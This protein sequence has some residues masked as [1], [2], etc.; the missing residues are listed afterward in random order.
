MQVAPGNLD[1][2]KFLKG[3]KPSPAFTPQVTEGV[4]DEYLHLMARNNELMNMFGRIALILA[5]SLGS[6][7]AMKTVYIDLDYPPVEIV[8][9]KSLA[10]TGCVDLF[11][12]VRDFRIVWNR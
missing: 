1:Y 2:D 11:G 12:D 8:S 5:I 4:A 6:G 10:I 9:Y 7:C 3:Y